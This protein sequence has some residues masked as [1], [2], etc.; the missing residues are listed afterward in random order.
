MIDW[1]GMAKALQRFL[2]TNEDVKKFISE[3]QQTA[4]KVNW[5]KEKWENYKVAFCKVV[6]LRAVQTNPA[7]MEEFGKTIYKELRGEA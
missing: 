7:L 4:I 3:A 6:F 5:S 2:N 1:D